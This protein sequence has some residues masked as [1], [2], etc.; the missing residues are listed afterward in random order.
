MDKN[1]KLTVLVPGADGPA[2]I[3]TIKSLRLANF[4]GKIVASDSSPISAGFF[5]SDESEIIPEADDSLFLDRLMKIILKHNISVLMPSS[6]YD[7]YPYSMV[8]DKLLK[9][10]VVA[11][12]SD[13]KTLQICRDKLTTYKVL[14]SKFDLPFTTIDQ[15]RIQEFPVIAKPRY[16]KGSRDILKISDDKELRYI[17]S[18][19]DDLVFQEYLPGTE[20]TIDVLSDLKQEPL[21]AVPRIRLQT[22]AGIS[23]KGRIVRDQRIEDVCKTIAEYLK[24]SGPCCIQ[25]KESKEGVLKFV[26]INPRLGGGT[27]FTTLAGVNLPSLIMDIVEGKE[28]DIPQFSEVTIIRYYEEIVIRNENLLSSRSTSQ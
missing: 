25:M 23:T 21:I 26:E 20:Y 15:N 10:G 7:I 24:V 22:K 4:A 16:G 28:I 1:G 17:L 19:Y 2:G 14:S 9:M 13:N 8:K 5:M 3:N 11:V 6:G 18:R 27:I 12:V